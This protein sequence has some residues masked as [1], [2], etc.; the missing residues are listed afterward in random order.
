MLYARSIAF[1]SDAEGYK[2][3]GY[4]L[5]RAVSEAKRQY[6]LKIEEYDNATDS[7]RMWHGLQHITDF[8]QRRH[9]VTTEVC[10]VLRKTNPRKAAGPDNTLSRV[11]RVC[12]P[13][14]AEVLTD[15]F[16]LSL[17][18]SVVPSCFDIHVPH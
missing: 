14:L 3:S 5:R 4:D 16:N 15:I 10:T 2:K 11:L 17:S 6:R 9:R 18:Q 8:Q 12:S 13:E 7:P 1:A